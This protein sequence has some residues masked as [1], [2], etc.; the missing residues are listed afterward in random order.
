MSQFSKILGIDYGERRVGLAIGL[1]HLKIAHPWKIVTFSSEEE[2]LAKIKRAIQEEGIDLIVVGVP[3]GLTQKDKL[4]QQ[5]KLTNDFIERLK[6][7]VDIPVEKFDE[8]LSSR[9]A[10]GRGVKGRIDDRAAQII[11]EDFLNFNGK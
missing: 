4:S 1:P 8:R 6:K 2:L 9:L 7:E 10:K 5:A 3:Y 11:L